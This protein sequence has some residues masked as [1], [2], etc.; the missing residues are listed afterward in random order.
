MKGKINISVTLFF[1]TDLDDEDIE[2]LISEVDYEFK[3]KLISETRIN[4]IIE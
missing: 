2:E 4:G 1:E 3:D